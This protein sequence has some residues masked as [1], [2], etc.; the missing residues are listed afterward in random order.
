MD[1]ELNQVEPNNNPKKNYNKVLIPLL[2]L[3][4]VGNGYLLVSKNKVA[5]QN[6]FLISE[7]TDINAAKDTLQNQ[8]D[9]ALVRLDDLTGKNAELDQMVQDKDG[10]LS[11]LKSE[12][13]S[14]LGK[15]NATVADLKKAQSLIGSLRGK[16]QGYEERISELEIANTNLTSENTQLYKENETVSAEAQKLKELGSVLHISNIKMEPINQKRNG[17]IEVET[18]KAKRV[19]ILR[20]VFDID[21]NRIAETG[22]NEIFVVIEAPNGKLLS[23]AA[24]GS[25]I[26]TDA[27]NN[28]LNYTVAKRINLEKGQKMTNVSVDWKQESEFTKGQYNISF[29]NRGY[30]IGTGMV[31]LR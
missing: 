27:D 22:F 14:L 7:N 2:A 26:T 24:F 25:G 11:K 6:N 31:Q 1:Q 17:E 5:E 20:I 21:E 13:K 15:K 18:T 12:I 29:Y 23:N 10:E 9:A 16:V 3:S 8:Y 4:L 19:D 28:P 30:K